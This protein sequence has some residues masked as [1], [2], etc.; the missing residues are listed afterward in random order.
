MST[1]RQIQSQE[2]SESITP[3][4]KKV[5]TEREKKLIVKLLIEKKNSAIELAEMFDIN[6]SSVYRILKKCNSTISVSNKVMSINKPQKLD[7]DDIAFNRNS[8]DTN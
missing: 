5:L 6:I 3:S 1:N 2:T 8:L 7:E 4:R